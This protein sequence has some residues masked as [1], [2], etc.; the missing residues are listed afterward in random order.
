MLLVCLKFLHIYV[1]NPQHHVM[2]VS[3]L[4]DQASPVMVN[5]KTIVSCSC[6]W[7][8]GPR[9][10]E[11]IAVPSSPVTGKSSP[12]ITTLSLCRCERL[13]ESA[14][15][16]CV[17]LQES[18][19]QQPRL[20]PQLGKMTIWSFA[21]S[22]TEKQPTS[23]HLLRAGVRMWPGQRHITAQL[24]CSH[25]HSRQSCCQSHDKG[26]VDICVIERDP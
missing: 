23:Q 5:L 26:C 15:S 10:T 11:T 21:L 24:P 19:T 3:C 6:R 9:E 16:C 18:P 20:M 8:V 7:P 1:T 4:F 17:P 25:P 13:P 22:V 14:Q 2:Q 12:K